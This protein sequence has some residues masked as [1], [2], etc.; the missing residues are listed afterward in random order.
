MR[1]DISK[2]VW[3]EEVG[4]NYAPASKEINPSCLRICPSGNIK[5]YEIQGGNLDLNLPLEN[6]EAD[7][8]VGLGGRNLT[9]SISV[10]KTHSQ[11]K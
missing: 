11:I 10:S 9:Q 7:S 2:K 6:I 8:F 1:E 5:K 3:G 4:Y